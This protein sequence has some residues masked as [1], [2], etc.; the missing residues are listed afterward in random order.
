MNNFNSRGF[1]WSA[2]LVVLAAGSMLALQGCRGQGARQEARAVTTL[3]G[4]SSAVV[5]DGRADEWPESIGIQADR[6][7][8]YFRISV[9]GQAPL[10]AS[11]ETTSLWLDADG[12]AKTGL[13][14][15]APA[16]A[17]GLG[18]DL[19]VEYSPPD[20]AKPGTTKRG[21]VIFA[22]DAAGNKTPLTHTQVGLSSLPTYG[23]SNYE[24]RISRHVDAAAAPDLAAALAAR[25]SARAMY[26]LTDASGKQLGWSDPETFAKPTAAATKALADVAIPPKAAGVVRVVSYNVL[27]SALMENPASFSRVFQVLDPDIILVQEWNADAA[28]VSSWFTATVTGVH[29]WNARVSPGEVVIVSPHPMKPLVPG[30]LTLSSGDKETPVRY[31]GA[32]VSTPLGDVA[33]GSVHLKCCGTAGSSED[34]RRLA[35]AR[36]INQSLKS[37]LAGAG[38]SMRIIAGDFNLVG[39]RGPLDALL[40]GLDSDGSDLAVAEARLLGD[41]TAVTW[42]DGK[43]EFSPGRLDYAVFGD[44]GAE[45]VQA[46]T[47]D[48]SRLSAR[49]LARVGLDPTDTSASDHLPLVIDLRPRQ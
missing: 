23:A 7:W 25:G 32:I 29:N 12:N 45:I 14:M 6:D 3:G 26:M 43:S 24:A 27:K 21:V 10:Q 4:Q 46:F 15:S 20:E 33:A 5:L 41:S 37:A 35:E 2:A 36:L 11:T 28:T 18:V 48:T 17:A 13:V 42:V 9:D 47:L 49:S 39:S 22:V 40:A 16:E 1:G 38:P 19:I 34:A 44:A 30:P 31:V 8:I